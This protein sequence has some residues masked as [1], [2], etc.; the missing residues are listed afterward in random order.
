MTKYFIRRIAMAVLTIFIV[1]FFSFVLM[2]LAPGDIV[3]YL[4]GYESSGP[5]GEAMRKLLGLDKSLIVRY[6]SWISQV[7][8]GNLGVSHIF[9]PVSKFIAVRLPV[10]L[11]MMGVALTV[12]LLFSIGIVYLSSKGKKGITHF[13][14]YVFS[15]IG[16][17]MPEFWFAGM[18]IAICRS[19]IRLFP[20]VGLATKY[21]AMNSFE[22]FQFAIIPTAIL[23]F[24]Y[25]ANN[26]RYV[27]TSIYEV[28]Q[29]EYITVAR[30]KGLS[31]NRIVF[32]H[33]LK[34]AMIPIITSV[35]TT[36]PMLISSLAI[37][38]TVFRFPGIGYAY[39]ETSFAR[40]YTMMMGLLMLTTSMIAFGGVIA[41]FFYMLVD[42]RIR[43][44]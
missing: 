13:L 27:K 43:Y 32:K 10:T 12:S 34:N 15:L 5:Q 20:Y 28:M 30:S 44:N 42:P 33:A 4:L 16:V 6:F 23:A 1:S 31:E 41:D 7:L 14:L 35:V 21:D 40:D 17:S 19:N 39:V 38:E 25:L 8:Q 24:V 26:I 36:L 29:N 3:T 2:S 9:G 37:V 22:R 11:A 18:A